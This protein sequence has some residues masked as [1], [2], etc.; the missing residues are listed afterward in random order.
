MDLIGKGGGALLDPYGSYKYRGG[1][2]WSP[3]GPIGT[4]GGGGR[5]WVPMDA[6]G[7]GGGTAVPL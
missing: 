7:T 6:I 3:M 2:C 5:C 1:H 4:E